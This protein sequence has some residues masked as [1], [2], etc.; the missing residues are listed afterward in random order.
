MKNNNNNTTTSPWV[1][2]LVNVSTSDDDHG[3]SMHEL[4]I[5]ARL[6]GEMVAMAAPHMNNYH[7]DLYYDSRWIEHQIKGP[8]TFRWSWDEWGTCIF[9][10]SYKGKGRAK[11]QYIVRLYHEYVTWR[12]EFT[13]IIDEEVKK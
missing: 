12:A 11:H 6:F 8:T 5:K 9:P 1:V 3:W 7:S 4:S 2:D 10:Y 13:P